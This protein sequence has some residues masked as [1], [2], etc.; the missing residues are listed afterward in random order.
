M[1]GHSFSFHGSGLIWMLIVGA[2]VVIPFWRLLPQY[3]I[4]SWVAILAIFPFAV[5]VLLWIMAFRDRAGGGP[6]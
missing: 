1:I 6:A 2:V 5:L 3:G 4:P